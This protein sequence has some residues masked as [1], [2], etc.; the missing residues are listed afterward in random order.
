MNK[1]RT[2]HYYKSSADQGDAEAQ[3]TDGLVLAQGEGVSMNK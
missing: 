2:V 3:F 1:S